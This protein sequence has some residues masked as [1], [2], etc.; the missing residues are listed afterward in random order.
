MPN[1]LII[2]DDPEIRST[3]ESLVRRMDFECLTAANLYQGLEKLASNDVDVVFLDV[4]LPDGN[5]L[6]ALPQIKEAPSHP[7][8]IILT[9]KGDPDGAELAIQ[10]GV[11]DYLV[12]PSPI[13]QTRLTLKRAMA[14]RAEKQTRKA[15]VALNTQGVIGDSPAVRQCFDVVAMAAESSFSVLISGETGTGKE[16]FARTIHKNSQ[17]KDNRFVVVDC[18]AL[19]EH[20]MESILFGHKKG[21]FTSAV[22]DRSGLVKQADGGTLFLDEMGELN[23]NAQKVFLRV[24]QERK[25]RPVGARMEISSDFRLIAATNRDLPKMVEEGRFRQDLYYRLKVI[26]L[27]LPPLRER[28]E[29][30]KALAMYYIN[31]L[32]ERAKISTKGIDADFMSTIRGYHWPGNVRELF[33]SLE[34]AF[35]A[36]GDEMTLFAMHLP[37]DIRIRVARQTIGNASQDNGKPKSDAAPDKEAPYNTPTLFSDPMPSIKDFKIRMEKLYLK[38]LISRSGADVN[39]ILKISKLSRSHFYA[40]LKRH[41]ISF[42]A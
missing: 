14:Y 36:S 41:G 23:P 1:I 11:W 8:V 2:D 32:S 37:P 7:E 15:L 29:D 39:T 35:V 18:A 12:K 34:Q 40:L 16:L 30:I 33:H 20:L 27:N 6:A 24:L 22:K 17:R 21:A 3:M 9:G 5:G 28:K 19:P 25:F 10:G 31:S 26:S 13:R 4:R 42:K 38:H